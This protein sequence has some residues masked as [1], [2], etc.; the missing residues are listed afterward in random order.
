MAG[1]LAGGRHGHAAAELAEGELH[2]GAHVE[3]G[4]PG[5]AIDQHGRLPGRDSRHG[6]GDDDSRSSLL[7]G[8]DFIL[9][10]CSLELLAR[11][12]EPGSQETNSSGISGEPGAGVVFGR[13]E[14]SSNTGQRRKH[15]HLQLEGAAELLGQSRKHALG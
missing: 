9:T 14:P 10:E 3:G 12:G 13:R 8:S 2:G 1:A 7:P 4:R 5:G 15:P 11:R 6:G